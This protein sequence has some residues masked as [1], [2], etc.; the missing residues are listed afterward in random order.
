MFGLT[1]LLKQ[2]L[3]EVTFGT[4]FMIF[5]LVVETALSDCG[6]YNVWIL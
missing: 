4:C 6:N 5:E 1:F 2:K 3:D